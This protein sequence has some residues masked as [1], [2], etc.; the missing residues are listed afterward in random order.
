MNDFIIRKVTEKELDQL[1]KIGKLTFFE[2]FSAGN[3]EDDMNDY[4]EVNFSKEK[5]TAEYAS[6]NS[7]FYFAA[8]GQNI[9][10][11]LKV[12]FG[13]GQTELRDENSIEIQRIYVLNSFQRKG[14]GLQLLEKSIQIAKDKNAAFI[15]LGVWEEN[16]RAI[17]F[18]KKFGFIEFAKHPFKFGKDMQTD[19]M[20]KLII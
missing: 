18:Y 4:L 3:G 9:I 15:W 8:S 10:G 11:Y 16:I 13:D 7:E 19:I 6:D 2:T 5:L 1:Q 12:N 14:V 17:N 20:M